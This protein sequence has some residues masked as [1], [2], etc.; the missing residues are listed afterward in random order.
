M[1]Y[2]VTEVVK[3]N[4]QTSKRGIQRECDVANE[5]EKKEKIFET[6]VA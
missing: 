5:K 3:I 1:L 4:K 6:K 2:S